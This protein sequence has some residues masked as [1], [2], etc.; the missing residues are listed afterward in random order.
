MKAIEIDDGEIL[1]I[2]SFNQDHWSF[3]CNNEANLYL[4]IQNQQSRFE[5]H[6]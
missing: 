3:Y 2:G 4:K 1:T 6:Q 5:L